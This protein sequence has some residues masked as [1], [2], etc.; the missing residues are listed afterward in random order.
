MN[1]KVTLFSGT[2]QPGNIDAQLLDL[3]GKTADLADN[4]IDKR[5]S[6]NNIYMSIETALIA[7]AYFMKNWW[8]YIVCV[9]GI[10]IAIMW[11]FSVLNYRSLSA[12]KYKII[13]E[14]EEKLPVKPLSYEWT[15]IRKEKKYFYYGNSK[16][17]I[18][19]PI[20]FALLYITVIICLATCGGLEKVI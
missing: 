2:Y 19:I 5:I 17:E 13:G 14:I 3:W 8:D 15:L 16:L 9:V 20:V 18:M 4:I 10:I 1:K 7:A 12:V 6:S 11:L